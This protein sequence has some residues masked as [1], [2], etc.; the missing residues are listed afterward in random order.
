M[1]ALDLHNHI[2]DSILDISDIWYEKV[3]HFMFNDLYLNKNSKRD[4][5]YYKW[6]SLRVTRYCKQYNISHEA[7]FERSNN[8][9]K[10]WNLNF[11]KYITKL[12]IDTILEARNISNKTNNKLRNAA[13]KIIEKNYIIK[14]LDDAIELVKK[15]STNIKENR[16]KVLWY[17]LW[18]Y[19]VT[20]WW[21][22][23]Y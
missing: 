6:L 7:F 15:I 3:L 16:I 2:Q 4:A 5:Q 11:V 1:G 13:Q 8:E 12:E 19:Y 9:V 22:K 20:L 14:D 17:Q 23:N 10:L 21:Q 18:N